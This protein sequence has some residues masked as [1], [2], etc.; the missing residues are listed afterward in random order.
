MHKGGNSEVPSSVGSHEEAKKGPD[1]VVVEGWDEHC[2]GTTCSENV[3]PCP[4]VQVIIY[5]VYV[6]AQIKSNH[7]HSPPAHR[8]DHVIYLYIIS[9]NQ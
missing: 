7:D 1:S 2:G 5:V 8:H 9:L 4:F 3:S 6:A